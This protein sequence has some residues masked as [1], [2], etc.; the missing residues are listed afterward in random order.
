MMKEFVY[1]DTE[2]VNSCLA[3]LNEG[4]L[5]KLTVS[6]AEQKENEEEGGNQI[7]KT[8]GGSLGVEG[9]VKG[10]GD[11][12]N[13]EFDKFKIVFSEANTELV[14]TILD[15]Y[16]LDVLVDKLGSERLLTSESVW[17]EGDFISIK[18]NF[19][20]YNFEILESIT[21][22][23]SVSLVMLEDEE[24][25]EAE[26]EL[27]TLTSSKALRNKH[28]ERIKVLKKFI[29]SKSS[30]DTFNLVNRFA[31][32][33]QLLYPDSILIRIDDTLSILDKKN[34]RVN[35]PTLSAM[36]Q[37]K[38]PLKM[39]GIVMSKRNKN[40][41]PEEGVQLESDIIAS[42][43]HSIFTEIILDSYNLLEDD[44]YFV[45]PIAIFFDLE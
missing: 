19:Y 6:K 16:S 2:L 9:L 11:Y 41:I 7:T 24:L 33:G 20:V 1:L 27:K 22:D 44:G 12:S 34:L 10:N 32:F 18:D 36:G 3:Q 37:T 42:S 29:K 25:I 21:R 15:D 14:D 5:T 31:A 13:T 30:K 43:T 45:R 40:I 23:E 26:T 8:V 17:S 39:I 35:S 38:R 4:L 28:S